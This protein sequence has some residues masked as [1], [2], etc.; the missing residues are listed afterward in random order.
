MSFLR[1][2]KSG[3]RR[4]MFPDEDSIRQRMIKFRRM[5]RLSKTE[6][7]EKVGISLNILSRME[8]NKT[9]WTLDKIAK[10][11]A[12]FD[13]SR[14]DAINYFFKEEITKT[15]KEDADIQYIAS[16][17]LNFLG[18]QNQETLESIKTICRLF[19]KKGQEM[20]DRE[21]DNSGKSHLNSDP[22]P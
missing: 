13:L 12:S 11:V 8:R 19:L 4:K 21:K 20:D 9:K 16:T 22:Q 3:K 10:V 14:D 7:A 18:S 17:L 6:F 5:H 1:R 15:N 2:F